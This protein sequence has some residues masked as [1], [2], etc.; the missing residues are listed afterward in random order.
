MYKVV[1]CND[2]EIELGSYIVL[3]SCDFVD[4]INFCECVNVLHFYKNGNGRVDLGKSGT[5]INFNNGK[6]NDYKLMTFDDVIDW[7]SKASDKL[8]KISNKGTEMTIK[9]IVSI[10]VMS[11]GIRRAS[12]I[13][14]NYFI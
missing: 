3:K 1:D 6:L 12:N 2:R 8:E 7:L 14:Q 11:Q 9:D 4:T 5:K 13:L 10:E